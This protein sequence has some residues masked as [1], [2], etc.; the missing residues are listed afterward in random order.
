[1][2][3]TGEGF[4]KDHINQRRK[5]KEDG[6]GNNGKKIRRTERLRVI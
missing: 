6:Y 2:N 5:R 1:M 3:I 4:R